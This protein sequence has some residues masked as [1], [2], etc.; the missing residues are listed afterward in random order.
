MDKLTF[1]IKNG[2][3]NGD[4][5]RTCIQ[6]RDLAVYGFD[7]GDSYIVVENLTYNCLEFRADPE[8]FE[9]LGNKIRKVSCVNDKRRGY[10]YQTI[11][12]RYS[13]ETRARLFGNAEKL[14]VTVI[15]GCI[16]IRAALA[17]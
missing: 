16:I 14:E 3:L 1:N 9:T 11:D 15:E 7:C 4:K 6:R 13:K 10:T 17:A 8:Q 12:Y 2:A 5:A